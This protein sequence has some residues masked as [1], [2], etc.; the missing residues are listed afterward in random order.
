MAT[1][2]TM[3]FSNK[4]WT[5]DRCSTE[6]STGHPCRQVRS[7]CPTCRYP[8]RS[9]SAPVGKTWCWQGHRSSRRCKRIL[10]TASGRQSVL[11]C[12]FGLCIDTLVL[13]KRNDWCV[14]DIQVNSH[15]LH[16]WGNKLGKQFCGCCNQCSPNWE[17]VGVYV[18]SCVVGITAQLNLSTF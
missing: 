5:Y 9:R 16:S 17:E 12:M 6:G 18:H 7:L 14:H 2:I 11:G 4:E 13:R 15:Q 10:S 1:A 3:I 8:D